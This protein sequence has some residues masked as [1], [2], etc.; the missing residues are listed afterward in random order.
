M[1]MAQESTPRVN[2]ESMQR[3]IGQRVIICCE[4]ESTS[5]TQLLVK[6]SDDAKITVLSGFTSPYTSKFV[7]I[8][9]TVVDPKTVQEEDHTN[10]GDGFGKLY[11]NQSFS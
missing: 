8:H 1:A 9:G 3:F 5:D 2:F 4:I 7:E 6:T 10:V 11:A